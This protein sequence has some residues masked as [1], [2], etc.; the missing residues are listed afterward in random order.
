[1]L[2]LIITGGTVVTPHTVAA[3][4]VGISRGAHRCRGPTRQP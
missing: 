4:D 1:M 2:D 3:L